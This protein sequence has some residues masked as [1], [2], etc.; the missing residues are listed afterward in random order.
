[1][2]RLANHHLLYKRAGAKEAVLLTLHPRRRNGGNSDSQMF[3]TGIHYSC[4]AVVFSPVPG[5]QIRSFTEKTNALNE[6]PFWT[7]SLSI[8]ITIRSVETSIARSSRRVVSHLSIARFVEYGVKKNARIFLDTFGSG[9]FRIFF[10]LLSMKTPGERFSKNPL[11]SP[12]RGLLYLLLEEGGGLSSRI[13]Q[14]KP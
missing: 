3:L 4:A 13:F 1:M 12:G 6:L 9:R 11:P 5:K 2:P 7:V 14:E 10:S 8:F